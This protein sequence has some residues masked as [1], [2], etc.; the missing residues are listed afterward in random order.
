MIQFFRTIIYKPLYNL[1]ILIT[2]F[3][4]GNSIAISIILVT[5]LVKLVLFPLNKKSIVSQIR[6]KELEPQI[7]EI[8][9][10]YKDDKQLSASKTFALYKEH[11]VSPFSGCLPILVQVP[12]ILSLYYVFFNGLDLSSEFIY[13]GTRLPEVINTNL[14]G[15]I[16]L[17]GKSIILAL[18]AGVS[19]F[20]L[21]RL[22]QSRTTQGN[23]SQKSDSSIQSNISKTLQ[24]QMKYFLPVFITFIAYQIS[25]AI[26][27]YWTVNNIISI[28]QERYIQ[29]K[30][31]KSRNVVVA[32][33]V[34]TEEA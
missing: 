12:I 16:D 11:K 18:T 1:L 9:E 15:I 24:F 25:G 14:L 28:I 8:K 10:K 26:A 2:A 17:A 33:V 20:F 34:R 21:I 30:Y 29:K 3:I 31:M 5:I 23:T 19:Q 6:L 4:P 32:E 7:N 27:L 13:A 22:S